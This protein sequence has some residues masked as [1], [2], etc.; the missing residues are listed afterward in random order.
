MKYTNYI[1]NGDFNIDSM[2][3]DKV[4]IRQ[5]TILL[6]IPVAFAGVAVLTGALPFAVLADGER[7]ARLRYYRYLKARRKEQHIERL[8]KSFSLNKQQQNNLKSILINI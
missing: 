6:S 5:A 2:L 4:G 1:L 8:L 3:S 7:Y